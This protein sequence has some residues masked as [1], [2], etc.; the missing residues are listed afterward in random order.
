MTG[1]ILISNPSGRVGSGFRLEVGF[2]PSMRAGGERGT[3]V[4]AACVHLE[5]GGGGPTSKC[6]VAPLNIGGHHAKRFH[7]QYALAKI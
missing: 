7:G 4:V 3:R 2:H 1:P 5:K 6:S